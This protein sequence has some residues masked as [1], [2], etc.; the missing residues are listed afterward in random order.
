M[1]RSTDEDETIET[2]QDIEKFNKQLSIIQATKAND[3][4]YH[5]T[6]NLQV[7][8]NFENIKHE[9]AENLKQSK[10][11]FDKSTEKFIHDIRNSGMLVEHKQ[12]IKLPSKI[13]E[14]KNVNTL[15]LSLETY[16]KLIPYASET[17]LLDFLTND[18]QLNEPLNVEALRELNLK[19]LK[20]HTNELYTID[21]CG[22]LFDCFN[23]STNLIL[24]TTEEKKICINFESQGKEYQKEY[25]STNY[26]N[27]YSSNLKHFPAENFSFD[28]QPNLSTHPGPSPS[29]ILQALTMS[30][31][32]DGINLER[33]ETIG[34]SFLKYAITT[35]LYITYENVHEGKL[36]HLR[37]K[38]VANLNLY[39]LGR[40]KQLGEYMIAT[41][42]EPSDNWLPPCYYVPKELEK[43]LIEAKIPPHYWS[44]VD[45]VNIKKLTNTEICELVRKKADEWGCNFSVSISSSLIRNKKF[46]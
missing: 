46:Q 4:D 23:D 22:D 40:R 13:R 7:G 5:E 11:Q 35:Y 1:S 24:S 26:T 18:G 25:P 3:R 28:Y 10:E 37:S 20:N 34:D 43:A 19:W 36:S 15:E 21:G 29:I 8:Y 32:N 12:N 6:K 27:I 2:E 31:A 30:N 38:Q 42:F 41:K 14:Y 17:D 39:R 16:K 44:L 9:I 33:L 45:L